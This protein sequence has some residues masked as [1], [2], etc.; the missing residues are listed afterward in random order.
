M[1][2]TE[3][4][5][6][7]TIDWPASGIARIV[8]ARGET[9]NTLTTVLLACLEDLLSEVEAAGARALIVTGSGKTFCGGA[10]IR[11]FTD[12]A[13]PLYADPR[14]IRDY[15]HRILQVFARLRNGPFVT[16]ASIGGHAL[17]GG[18]ELA[19]ACDF[20]LM[21]SE[22][23]IGLPET[24]LG[25]VAGGG[26]VQLLSR[27]VGRAKALEFV[28]PGEQWT[29]EAARSIGLVTA[30]HP[31]TELEEASVALARRFLLCSPI[32]I[33]ETKRALYRC[34]AATAEEA[35]RIALDAVAVAAS[36]PEWREGM[37]A[38]TERRIPNFR[39]EAR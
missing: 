17:G 35:D 37:T 12:P 4:S 10:H 23:R 31:A 9:H 34:E 28:L 8:L 26:G 39:L 13:S 11:Y 20:R 5:R 16:I 32:S 6:P 36:G 21:A 19:L 38:F 3:T 15:V 27:I 18:C 1:T 2:S 33:A 14:G 7:A 30:V 25:A 22:A 29:A 24:R